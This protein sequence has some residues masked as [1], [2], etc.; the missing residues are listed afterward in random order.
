MLVCVRWAW[1]P[2]TQMRE[3]TLMLIFLSTSTNFIRLNTHQD[4]VL[5]IQKK[6]IKIANNKHFSLNASRQIII[7]LPIF[8]NCGVTHVRSHSLLTPLS[9]LY[10]QL[11]VYQFLTSHQSSLYSKLFISTHVISKWSPERAIALFNHLLQ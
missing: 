4:I 11:F 6:N 2:N 10:D 7:L 9:I 3:W 8:S 1:K 5:W